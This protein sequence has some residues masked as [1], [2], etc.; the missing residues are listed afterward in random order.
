MQPAIALI[1]T[2]LALPSGVAIVQSG[3]AP[4]VDGAVPCLPLDVPTLLDE[5]GDAVE[6]TLNF[7]F[8][9][10]AAMAAG[11]SLLFA[12]GADGVQFPGGMLNAP[13]GQLSYAGNPVCTANAGPSGCGDITAVLAGAGLAGGGS[14]GSVTLSIAPGGVQRAMIA[15]EAIVRT[16]VA[17]IFGPFTLTGAPSCSNVLTTSVFVPLTGHVVVDYSTTV[18]IEHVAGDE[19]RVRAFLYPSSPGCGQPAGTFNVPA[20][21]PTGTYVQS[22]QGKADFVIGT[23]NTAVLYLDMGMELGASAGDH[24]LCCT[25]L[26]AVWYPP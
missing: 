24:L 8:G 21:L 3:L 25:V 6:G 7:A 14:T 16:G 4:A 22:M 10:D 2:I 19:D 9:A 26:Q 12:N 13:A 23:G 20:P 18:S 17:T 11:S 5:C 15:D 1:A